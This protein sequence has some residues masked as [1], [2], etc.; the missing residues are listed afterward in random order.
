ML[1]LKYAHVVAK[2]NLL[3]IVKFCLNVKNEHVITASQHAKTKP[4]D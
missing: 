1:A 3:D 2:L 4:Q